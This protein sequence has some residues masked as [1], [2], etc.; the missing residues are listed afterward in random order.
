SF[1]A[2]DHCTF[3]RQDDRSRPAVSS[4]R[5]D[6]PERV[7]STVSLRA[8]PW[9]WPI[10][11][12]HARAPAPRFR[13]CGL[14]PGE[15]LSVSVGSQTLI[16]HE[17]QAVAALLCKALRFPQGSGYKGNRLCRRFA[18]TPHV[19]SI[20]ANVSEA[21]GM[22]RVRPLSRVVA[23]AESLRLLPETASCD[24]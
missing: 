10:A 2:L 23:L 1:P 12:A 18:V 7:G 19:R 15:L 20:C 4:D 16:Y 24:C 14:L 11:P 21:S 3:Y 17:S 5:T 9:P 22:Q 8:A 13:L 6:L